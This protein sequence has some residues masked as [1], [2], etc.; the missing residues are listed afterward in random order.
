MKIGVDVDGVLTDLEQYQLKYG[1]E[2]FKKSDEEIDITKSSI[3][4]IFNVSKEETEKFWTKYIWKYSLS[5]PLKKD[6]VALLK[7]LKKAGYQIDII[8][9]RAHTTEQNSVGSLFRKML[10]YKLKQEGI[11]YDNIYY[12]SE[13]NSA[14]E[15]SDLCNQLGIDIMIEDS[16][17]NIEEISK[18]C[19]VC[20][21]NAS[22]N[23]DVIE[24]SNIHRVNNGNDIYEIIKKKDNALTGKAYIEKDKF[25]FKYGVVRNIGTPLFKLNLHPTIIDKQFIPKDGPILLC[26]N[27]LHVWD[28]FPV[29][30]S[31]KRVTHWMAKKEYFD[32]K[33]GPFFRQTGAISVDRYGNAKIAEQEA[34]NYLQNDSAVGLFPE[35]TRNKLKEADYEELYKLVNTSCSLDEFKEKINQKELIT[36]QVNKLKE[37]Y[38]NKIIDEEMFV[39]ILFN[40]NSDCLIELLNKGI[41]SIDEYNDSL[42]LPFKFGAVSMAKRTNSLIVPFAVTGDYKIGNDNLI[43]RFGEP[44]DVSNI[45]LEEANQILRDKVLSL[46]IENKKNK[47]K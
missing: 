3:E 34:L 21:V 42:L 38:I 33:L 16:T 29:I 15:K 30:C 23:Q 5:E 35:G 45:D 40:N 37:L 6:M 44:L 11:K 46:V 36:S 1:K 20:C 28:Q 22:Y 13:E 31:T 47:K 14:K 8:T 10:I 32:G 41:I 18:V 27:H 4:K 12:C 9:S 19:E 39:N 26:G 25:K 7:K 2:Y 24:N 17:N 43:V